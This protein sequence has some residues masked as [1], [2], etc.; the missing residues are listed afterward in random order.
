MKIKVSNIH[1]EI[2]SSLSKVG[3]IIEPAWYHPD[4]GNTGNVYIFCETDYLEETGDE[5]VK[6]GINKFNFMSIIKDF[7]KTEERKALEKYGIVDG[8][9]DLTSTGQKEF[10]DFLFEKLKE[11]KKEFVALIVKQYRIDLGKK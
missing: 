6:A 10:V 3:D 7:F 8:N 11:E 1:G 9:G 2:S 4:T 5:I